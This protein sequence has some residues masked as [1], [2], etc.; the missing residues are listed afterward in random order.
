MLDLSSAFDTVD[1][2]ILLNELKVIGLQGKALNL[3]R[4][5]LTGRT[6]SVTAHGAVS[7]SVPLNCGVPQ[8]SILGPIL[9]S[10]YIRS[11][12]FLLDSL[13]VSYHM[14]ADDLQIYFNFDSNRID[15]LKS[16]VSLILDAISKWTSLYKLKLNIKK[17][18]IMI[19]GPNATVDNTRQKFGSINFN[20][21]LLT[22]CDEA[23]NLGVWLDYKLDF[24]KHITT[25]IQ[26]CNFRLHNLKHIKP[27]IPPK[28]LIAVIH[29]E[30]IN[31]IDYCNSLFFLLP[32]RQLRRLQV[33]INRCARV[34][35]NLPPRASVIDYL[36]DDLHWLPIGARIDFKLLLIIHKALAIGS[37]EY[38]CDSLTPSMCGGL[39]RP[40]P[41]RGHAFVDRSFHISAPRLYNQLPNDFKVEPLLPFKKKT[42]TFLYDTAFEQ[43][44]DSVL[45][46][47][48][49]NG[50][51]RYNSRR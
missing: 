31:R 30:V 9:F 34:I 42:K 45:M 5:F 15:E 44:L 23:K 37:P 50:V 25:L 28:L 7:S 19:F 1:H 46:Y 13:G 48:A 22:P 32:K 12:T 2:E 17:T 3:I 8:G 38:I 27:L 16:R 10:I 26:A 14:Y 6:I 33:I 40:R 35:F 24:N 21:H 36:K 29:H 47:R 49:S 43:R 18:H 11:V 4:S 51:Y 20:A 39:Y 41:P